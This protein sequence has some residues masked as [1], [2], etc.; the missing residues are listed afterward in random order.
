[1]LKAID[2]HAHILTG[3]R[4][5]QGWAHSA[6]AGLPLNTGQWRADPDSMAEM[7][8]HHEM[9]AVIFDVDGET[10]SVILSNGT[11]TGPRIGIQ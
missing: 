2:T 1:M 3:E 8:Q 4:A 5:K 7:Y 9:M 6:K 11:Q 10:R